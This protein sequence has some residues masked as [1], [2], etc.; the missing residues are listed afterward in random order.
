MPIPQ[1]IALAKRVPEGTSAA[2]SSSSFLWNSL[3]QLKFSFSLSPV[4]LI[5]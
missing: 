1:W 2:A 4:K 3:K 5:K